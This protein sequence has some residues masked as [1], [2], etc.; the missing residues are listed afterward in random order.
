MQTASDNTI[1]P[2]TGLS[3]IYQERTRQVDELGWTATHD[4]LHDTYQLLDAAETYI[5]AAELGGESALRI[6]SWPWPE[7]TFRP[8]SKIRNLV[9]AGALI[10]AEIDRL[11]RLGHTVE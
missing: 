4:D 7:H 8:E 2:F 11:L 1:D 6:G 10:A 5:D 3:L 9:K